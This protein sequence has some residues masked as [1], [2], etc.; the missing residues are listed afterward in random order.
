MLLRISQEPS[1]YL[2]E[3]CG[4]Y[5]EQRADQQKLFA[6]NRN[7]T[8]WPIVKF[9]NGLQQIIY[10]HCQISA[11]GVDK[12]YS[13]IGRTQ[14]PLL[15]AWAVTVH[16]SQGMTLSRVVVDLSRAFQAEML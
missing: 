12:P 8:K 4:E 13:L 11:L 6:Q 15:P 1:K 9:Q 10:G 5:R 3:V 16:K 2:P 14:I 7:I